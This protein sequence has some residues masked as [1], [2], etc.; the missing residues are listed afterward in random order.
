M[1]CMNEMH[2]VSAPDS[3]QEMVARHL[4]A[5]IERV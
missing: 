1:L 2:T 5:V 3:L 4:N